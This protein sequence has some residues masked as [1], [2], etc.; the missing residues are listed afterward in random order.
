[1][2]KLYLIKLITLLSSISL[3]TVFLLYRVGFFENLTIGEQNN[4]QTSHNGGKFNSLKVNTIENKK[5]SSKS[6]MLSSSKFMILT[7]KKSTFLDS[8]KKKSLKNKYPNNPTEILSSSKSAI[9]FKPKQ[10]FNLDSFR[11][12]LDSLK[13]KK[14]KG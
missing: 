6:L 14:K 11:I 7:D 5:D 12:K 3:V 8:L 9:I 4:L 10:S 1:M 13:A 2:K